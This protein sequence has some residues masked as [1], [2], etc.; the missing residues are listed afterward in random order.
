MKPTSFLL[1]AGAMLAVSWQSACA[2]ELPPASTPAVVPE[3]PHPAPH[4]ARYRHRHV[5]RLR[6]P[7]PVGTPA[8]VQAGSPGTT[9]APVPNEDIGPPRS[10]PDTSASV[11]PGSLSIHYPPLG[12]GYLP[13]SSP[14]DMANTQT[15]KV[16]GVTVK[17]PLDEARPETLPPPADH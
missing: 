5:M 8:P 11:N 12:Q 16:P 13:G 3:K 14:Q 4:H 1:L 7:A 6:P 10:P 15:P 9:P 2:Q 17:V